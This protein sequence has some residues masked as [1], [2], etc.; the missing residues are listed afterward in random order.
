ML[1]SVRNLKKRYE[2]RVVL[3][4]PDLFIEEGRIYGLL[5]PNGSGKSTLLSILSFLNAPSSGTLF[6]NDKPVSFTE[7]ALQTLRREVVLVDQ[8]P[9]LFST[10]VYKNVEFG[11]R[12]RKIPGRERR[13]IVE[14]ALDRVGMREFIH[15]RGN[16]LSGGETQRVA[17]ARAL[18]C[19]PKVMLFDEPTASV[20]VSNQIIIEN[21][22]RDLHTDAGISV[23]LSTHNLLQAAK[24]SQEKIFLFEG[25]ANS[26]TY[27]NIFTGEAVMHDGQPCCRIDDRFL[28]PIGKEACGVI[29]IAINPSRS[30]F[31]KRLQGRAAPEFLRER[32]FN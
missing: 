7:K 18:A 5:G 12:I 32:F 29:R 21:I 16:R 23:I 8:H 14:E 15:A 25:R 27:E 20:D 17:I 10:S 1:Y 3:D 9:I 30:A 31:Q 24:L 22:I 26:S 6:Y 11:L 13:R 4:L 19:S 2:G 28:V